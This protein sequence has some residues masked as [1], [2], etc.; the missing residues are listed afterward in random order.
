MNK[1]KHAL[2][3][4]ARLFQNILWAFVIVSV[5]SGVLGVPGVIAYGFS[6]RADVAVAVTAVWWASLASVIIRERWDSTD[7]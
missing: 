7:K 6:Q 5:G 1:Y 2:V 4:A 3:A